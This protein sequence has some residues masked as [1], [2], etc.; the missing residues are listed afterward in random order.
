M[1][2]RERFGDPTAPS[3]IDR[4]I[5]EGAEALGDAR[6]TLD[7]RDYVEMALGSGFPEAALGRPPDECALWLASYLGQLATRDV[8]EAHPRRDPDRLRRFL[9]AF[10]ANT[11]GVFEDKTLYEAA[12]VNRKTAIAYEQLFKNLLVVEWTSAWAT[13][14]LK[15]L[16]R[17]PKR[18]LTDA[19]LLGPLL[20]V[21]TA[22]VL[23]D[24]DLLGRVL[25]TFVAAQLRAELEVAAS[26]GRLFHLRTRD[27]RQE[28]D[29]VIETPQGILGFEV[30]ATA[31]P[32]LR[33]AR[34]LRWLKEQLGPGFRLGI[35]LHT[36]PR[37]F[38]LDEGIVAAP[39]SALWSG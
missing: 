39:I 15:R 13:N 3:V 27:Q 17:S 4:L 5:D 16:I 8:K 23:R 36:G 12:A 31:S 11:A 1:T 24:G 29:L 34:H 19:G 35:V 30:K 37:P 9:E 28:V 6:S 7:L 33:D 22:Q 10:A 25:D 26:R 14:R 21:G 38:E 32:S 20:L 2:G 18:Y